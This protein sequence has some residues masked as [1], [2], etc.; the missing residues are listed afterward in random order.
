MFSCQVKGK[1]IEREREER[2]RVGKNGKGL[3]LGARYMTYLP[4]IACSYYSLVPRP[5]R[6]KACQRYYAST[7][8]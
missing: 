4:K 5:S 7:K 6:V 3:G 8:L 1:G 2:T